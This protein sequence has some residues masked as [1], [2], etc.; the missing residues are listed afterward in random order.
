LLFLVLVIVAGDAVVA[1]EGTVACTPDIM[2]MDEKV[3]V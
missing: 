1:E 3:P 2:M